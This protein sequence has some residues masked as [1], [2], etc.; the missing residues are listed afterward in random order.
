MFWLE[1]KIRF[2]LYNFHDYQFII[3]EQSIKSKGK[4]KIIKRLDNKK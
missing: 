4:Q 3:S 1:K 2:V